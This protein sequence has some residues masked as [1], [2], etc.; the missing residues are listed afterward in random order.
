MA[1]DENPRTDLDEEIPDQEHFEG[2][3]SDVEDGQ[4]DPETGTLAAGTTVVEELTDEEL[5]RGVWQGSTI[6]EEYM[7]RR[8]RQI[9]DGVET[10]VPPAGEIDP[11]PKEGEYVVFYSHFD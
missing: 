5:L 7:L 2:E 4:A 6:T 1:T 10:R 8:R 11:E 9:L 3:L